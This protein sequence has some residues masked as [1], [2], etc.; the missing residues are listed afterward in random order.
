MEIISGGGLKP[1]ASNPHFFRAEGR[2]ETV[3]F[4]SRKRRSLTFVEVIGTKPYTFPISCNGWLPE[5][6]E[7]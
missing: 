5:G 3:L 6:N 2:R 7:P 4:H 1:I